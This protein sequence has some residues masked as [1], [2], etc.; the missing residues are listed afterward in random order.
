M[1]NG[2]EFVLLFNRL[3]EFLREDTGLG[4][5]YSF[6][7]LIDAAER[8]NG[9]VRQNQKL[10]R[11]FGGLRNAII[12]DRDYPEKILADPRDSVLERFRDIVNQILSP[13]KVIP[14]FAKKLRVFDSTSHLSDALQYMKEND[15][16]QVVAKDTGEYC[17]L[18]PEG[19]MTW[20][21]ESLSDDLVSLQEV[22]AARHRFQGRRMLCKR[23]QQRCASPPGDS[24]NRACQTAGKPLR[25]YYSLGYNR[26]KR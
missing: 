26:E 16:S 25:D 18:T 2:K 12:H 1:H 17:L 14:K 24:Y 10:L 13:E 19:I 4:Q 22:E 3:S 8:K 20:L 6:S 9:I 21:R 5:G 23:W 7:E 11:S 15:Y